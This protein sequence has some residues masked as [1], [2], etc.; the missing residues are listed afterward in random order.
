VCVPQLDSTIFPLNRHPA[1][2]VWE[3]SRSGRWKES[4]SC[5][6]CC[7]ISNTDTQFCEI[8]MSALLFVNILVRWLTEFYLYTF[9]CKATQHAAYVIDLTISWHDRKNSSRWDFCQ[10]PTTFIQCQLGDR[11]EKSMWIS[12]VTAKQVLGKSDVVISTIL[13]LHS[14]HSSVK[15]TVS[16]LITIHMSKRRFGKRWGISQFTEP[17]RMYYK[18]TQFRATNI[19]Y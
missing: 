4:E 16:F 14:N 18:V 15:M 6:V 3:P 8:S 12:F 5:N 2:C 19:S 13:F 11:L 1:Y 17:F 9:W 10:E 7:K